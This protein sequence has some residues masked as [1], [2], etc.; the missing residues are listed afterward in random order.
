MIGGASW[1]DEELAGSH[2]RDAHL[3]RRLRTMMAQMAGA[4]GAPI[5][6]ACQDWANTKAAHCF[7]SNDDVSERAIRAGHFVATDGPVL[8]L[9][10]TTEFSLQRDC[11]D[12]R[13]W[14]GG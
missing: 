12:F 6:L 2:V 8:V 11:Q 5:P 3:G 7:L 4:V 10:D 14:P 9:Q 1:I 13:V